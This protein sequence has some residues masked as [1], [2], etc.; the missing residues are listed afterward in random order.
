MFSS[1]SPCRSATRSWTW[2]SGMEP[3][4]IGSPELAVKEVG[5]G[6]GRIRVSTRT[7]PTRPTSTGCRIPRLPD[8]PAETT[9]PSLSR[10]ST[11][12]SPF[13]HTEPPLGDRPGTSA[14]LSR[15]RVLPIQFRG[16]CCKDDRD[17]RFHLD[18]A[19]SKGR[20]RFA[21]TRGCADRAGPR[22]TGSGRH[23]RL[24][25]GRPR[26]RRLGRRRPGSRCR[27]DRGVLDRSPVGAPS[28]DPGRA[29]PSL[30]GRPPDDRKSATSIRCALIL[31]PARRWRHPRAL[32]SDDAGL[33]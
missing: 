30:A 17:D 27:G 29:S 14:S 28:H 24:V 2:M 22:R 33:T 7:R 15:F 16:G 31:F 4:Q 11:F 25:H 20:C 21:I 18:A 12:K 32:L 6:V 10:C 5:T 3:G 9:D 23:R 1:R 8:H 26:G 19:F 13:G